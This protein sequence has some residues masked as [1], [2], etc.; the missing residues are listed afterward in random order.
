[1]SDK[2]TTISRLIQWYTQHGYFGT[3]WKLLC[4]TVSDRTIGFQSIKPPLVSL[5]DLKWHLDL[6]QIH[7]Y[8][9]IFTFHTLFGIIKP[10]VMQIYIPCFPMHRFNKQFLT[11]HS[12]SKCSFRFWILYQGNSKIYKYIVALLC[13]VIFGTGATFGLSSVLKGTDCPINPFLNISFDIQCS[14]LYPRCIQVPYYAVSVIFNICMELYG[15]ILIL[16]WYYY[17]L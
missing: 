6:D 4:G 2:V 3:Q 9:S 14:N 7:C 15:D 1:M 5:S 13:G 11:E 17:I 10:Q 16:L 8:I 12:T